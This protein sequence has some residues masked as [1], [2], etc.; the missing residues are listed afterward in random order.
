[1]TMSEQMAG[2][3]AG[4]VERGADNAVH[5]DLQALQ[6]FAHKLRGLGDMLDVDEAMA[7]LPDLRVPEGFCHARYTVYEVTATGSNGEKLLGEPRYVG[8]HIS[9][10]LEQIELR[11]LV[12]SAAVFATSDQSTSMGPGRWIETF[13]LPVTNP[14]T[15]ELALVLE[16]YEVND[17]SDRARI[18][19]ALRWAKDITARRL[20]KRASAQPSPEHG[21]GAG[22][23]S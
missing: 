10:R 3:M 14:G 6:A 20:Q 21:P 23:V 1:M 8:S 4:L 11:D 12:C 2:A 7:L 15:I 17:G 18:K 16:P 13:A 22:A 5:H 19:A 9:G